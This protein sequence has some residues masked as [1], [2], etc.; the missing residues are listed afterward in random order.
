VSTREGVRRLAGVADAV[1][2][3]AITLLVLP[4]ADVATQSHGNV[5]DLLSDHVGQVGAFAL[6]FVVTARLSWNT[7]SG[8]RRGC[9]PHS[10]RSPWL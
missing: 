2:A 8:I 5:G 1:V 9:T 4:L 7:N 3:I 6:S 10:S